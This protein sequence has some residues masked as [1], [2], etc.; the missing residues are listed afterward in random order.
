MNMDKTKTTK[1]L[2]NKQP[3][4]WFWIISVIAL[5]WFLMDTS[6]FFMRVLMTEDMLISM[7]ENQRLHIQNIPFWVNFVF[8]FEVFGGTLGC[9]TLLLRK[10]LAKHFFIISL[11]GVL[12][13]TTYIYFFSNSIATI[14]M[15]AV[16]MPLIAIMIGIGMIVVSKISISKGWL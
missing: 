14:G 16:V 3:A 15:T 4:I 10:K 2:I 1:F 11:L 5:L 12:S 7:P 13:Q 6:A 9:L 8:A